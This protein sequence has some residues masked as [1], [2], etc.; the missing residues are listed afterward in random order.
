MTGKN[1]KRKPRHGIDE[2]GRTALH[3]AAHDGDVE[4]IKALIGEGV[5]VNQQ[6]DNGWTPLHFAAQLNHCGAIGILLENQANPNLH[7]SHGN[8]PLWT[9][10][11]NARGR[12]AGIEA[13]LKA[14]ADPAHSNAHGRSPHEMAK[15]IQGGLEDVF[16]K[17][18]R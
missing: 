12:Y 4:R 1:P 9:A 11:M 14:G 17:H 3:Y 15:T 7:D 6:D 8:G 5:D 16:E 2:Y 13:L 18:L 10:T